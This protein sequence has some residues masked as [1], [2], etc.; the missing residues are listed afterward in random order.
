MGI[1]GFLRNWGISLCSSR[2]KIEVQ[3]TTEVFQCLIP[4]CGLQFD[5]RNYLQEHYIEEH[6]EPVVQKAKSEFV[7]KIVPE[8][9]IKKIVPDN[10][11]LT[12]NTKDLKEMLEALPQDVLYTGPDEFEDDFND[13]LN[14]K[15]DKE[16][17]CAGG[18]FQCNDCKF[19]T[20]TQRALRAH[21][22]FVHETSFFV[23]KS[24]R[25]RTK[26][27]GA[28]QLHISRVHN[29]RVIYDKPDKPKETVGVKVEE[30][31][32]IPEVIISS[33]SEQQSSGSDFDDAPALYVEKRWQSG[34]NYKSRT[35]AF[36]K[37]A[38]NLQILLRKRHKPCQIGDIQMK[39]LEVTKHSDGKLAKVEI[40]DNEGT[41]EA[42]FHAWEPNKR[43]KETTIQVDKSKNGE[44]KHVDILAT[45]IV[46]PFLDRL[47]SG[48]T[49]KNIMK[50]SFRE[51]EKSAEKIENN[52]Y[53]CPICAKQY[54]TEKYM[55]TH[56]SRLHGKQT[57]MAKPQVNNHNIKYPA[58]TQKGR[59]MYLS[60]TN[61]CSKQSTRPKCGST[62]KNH[63]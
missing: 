48:E 61:A 56:I 47:L 54:K 35:P 46:K 62:R 23:C 32:Q 33:E 36:I 59:K 28:M 2:M 50:V 55:K 9:L 30:V 26:T 15:V 29:R 19:K 37:A 3:A 57:E 20:L 34:Y 38:E 22:K 43:T 41:G 21:N 16:S 18:R 6:S 49:A 63:M 52:K 51:V 27:T 25:V 45:K 14:E 44:Q 58:P 4:T 39:V 24:C 13:I 7:R 10:E 12:Q 40:A 8:D 42:Q 1:Q 11:F 17:P 31:K 53:T 5:T 60:V